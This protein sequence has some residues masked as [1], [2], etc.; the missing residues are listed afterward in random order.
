MHAD[1]ELR[2]TD[3]VAAQRG[4][5]GLRFVPREMHSEYGPL[6]LYTQGSQQIEIAFDGMPG[7]GTV[8]VHPAIIE[9]ALTVLVISHAYGR[10]Y[11]V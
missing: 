1:Q 6:N 4:L 2:F 3:S 9:K 8:D 11:R 10:A 7:R 5:S